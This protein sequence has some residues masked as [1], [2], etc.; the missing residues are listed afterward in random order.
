M[1]KFLAVALALTLM[2][3]AVGCGGQDS[4]T[5][6]DQ[7]E[8]KKIVI[9]I[10]DISS[11]D[12]PIIKSEKEFKEYVERESNG[13]VVVE[14]YPNGQ[15]GGD[16]ENV[17]G[18]ML[19][20]V[21]MTMTPTAVLANWEEKFSVL[22]LPFLF[23][24]REAAYAACD[25]ELG[26]RLNELLVPL[27]LKSFGYSDNGIRHMTNNVRPINEPKDLKGLKMRIMESPI[28]V[29]MF[30]CLG[31]NATPMGFGELYTALQQ[32]Q[33]D[34]QENGFTLVY[35]TK[36]HEVQKYMSLTGHVKS[37][38]VVFTNQE[39]FDSLPADIQ[40]IIEEG[41][42]KYL[43]QRQRELEIEA[44]TENRNNIEGKIIINEITPENL[45]KFKAAVQP[46]YE[47]WAEKVGM[48]LIE[49]AQSYN[50]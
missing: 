39:W 11:E 40:K 26:D 5:G 10:P 12:T 15:L 3:F 32:G 46:M 22:D 1:R 31:A 2:L 27:G 7:T 25:G 21:H 49:L 44:D 45:E 6:G 50:K 18:V 28:Y 23:D 30:D 38:M 41:A 9:K 34:G 4:N 47:K 29:D 36:F 13:R 16:R 24:T 33:V 37:M 8:D 17:E 14:L 20:T 48:D 43:V 42:K 35:Q 19:G